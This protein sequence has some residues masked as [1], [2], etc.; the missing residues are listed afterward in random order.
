[1]AENEPG[2]SDL[3]L[4]MVSKPWC[5]QAGAYVLGF[6]SISGVLVMQVTICWPSLGLSKLGQGHG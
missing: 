5:D 3:W 6:I 4:Q 1:M 2:N